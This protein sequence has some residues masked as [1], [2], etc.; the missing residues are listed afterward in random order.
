MRVRVPSP[1]VGL[2]VGWTLFMPAFVHAGQ[3]VGSAAQSSAPADAQAVTP[4]TLDVAGFQ[5]RG[6]FVGSFDYNSRIQMVP[7]FAGGAQALA[8]PGATNFRFDKFGLAVYRAFAPWLSGSAAIEVERHSD[9]H[10]HGFNPTF[11]C[12][13]TATCIERFGSEEPATEVNLD[14]FNLTVTAPVGNGLALSLGRVD[15]PFGIERHDEP[16]NLTATTSEVFQ[17]GRPQRMT[18]FQASYVFNPRL[19]VT[20]W[21]VNRWESETTDTPFDDN[22]KSKSVGWRVGITPQPRQR[23]LNFGFGGFTGVER[24]E[25]EDRRWVIAVDATAAPSPRFFVAAEIISGGESGGSLRRRGIPYE[26]PPVD[27]ADVRWWGLYLLP[28]YDLG[29]WFGLSFRYGYFD[30]RDGARTGIAQHLQSWSFV[31]VFHLSRAVPGLGDTGTVYARTRH[32]INWLD[33][34]LEY[35]VNRSNQ[36]VFSDE[37]PAVNV[38]EASRTG[39]QI[40]VQLVMNF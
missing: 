22:N 1:G 14:R 2:A 9:R 16:L 8:D 5:F 30:D 17:F 18:G 11:G 29:E 4:P 38:L 35:R 19:D 40:Q 21:V 25:G 28:H 7:E 3:A 6:F 39:H 23:L 36:T 13:G 33:L 15:L 24:D 20:G 27:D 32:A 34:K 10:S 26:A 37:E 31:P 12:P